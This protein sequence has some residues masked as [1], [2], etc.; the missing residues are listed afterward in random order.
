MKAMKSAQ[1][2]EEMQGIAKMID[3]ENGA[4]AAD[5]MFTFVFHF[6][7]RLAQNWWGLLGAERKRRCEVGR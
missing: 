3:E 4:G 5:E 2:I 1:C 6:T 7:F